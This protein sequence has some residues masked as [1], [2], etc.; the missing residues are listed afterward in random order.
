MN[1]QIEYKSIWQMKFNSILLLWSVTLWFPRTAWTA[2]FKSFSLSCKFLNSCCPNLLSE[3][4]ANTKCSTDRKSSPISFLCFRALSKIKPRCVPIIGPLVSPVTW[5]KIHGYLLFFT[6]KIGITVLS[7]CTF[8][9]WDIK[10]TVAC[11]TDELSSPALEN[12]LLAKPSFCSRSA[13]IKCSLSTTC[14]LFARAV[15][16]APTMPSHAI[17]VKSVWFI[18]LKR[19]INQLIFGIQ[20]TLTFSDQS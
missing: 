19:S 9:C 7:R 8:G 4:K 17:S 14:C 2:S 16:T 3:W 10:S 1:K 12:I 6:K 13:F 18:C 5:Y 11:K 20:Q 15:S